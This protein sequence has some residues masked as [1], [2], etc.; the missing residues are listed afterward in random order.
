VARISRRKIGDILVEA[1]AITEDQLQEALAEQKHSNKR[2]G[3]LLVEKDFVTEE[4]IVD[5]L[6]E[7]LNI[8]Q[9]NL[10]S[11]DI[12]T[13]VATSIPSYLAQ[14]YNVIPIAQEKNKVIL[15]MADPMNIVA[16]DDVA[17]IT[18]KQVE[19]A[20]ATESSIKHAISQFFGM[21][22]SKRETSAGQ[23]VELE[24]EEELER[25]RA[26][27]EDAPI[28]RVV[29]S[30]IAQA[31]KEG[32]SDIHM[33]PFKDGFQVRMR[34]DG[35]LQKMAQP[36]QDTQALLVSRVKIMANLDIAERRLPQDGRIQIKVD[37]RLGDVNMRVSTMPTIHGEK[38]VIRIL[39]KEKIVLP[40]EKLGL[41]DHNY[42]VFKQLLMNHS[43]MILVTGPTGCGKT[44]TLYSALNYLN[45]PQDN[46]ITVEDPVEYYLN[47]INQVQ[48]NPRVD[49][50]FARAL[51]TIL[52]QDPDIIMVGEIRDLE[53]AEIATRA[54]LTG[55]LVLSS[56][57]TNTA[58][59]TVSRLIDMGVPGYL[60]VSSV[61]GVMTQRLV[62]M[63]C[64][65]CR[66]R[67]TPNQEDRVLF[68]KLFGRKAPEQLVRGRGC[69][70]CNRSGYRGRLAIHEIM[71]MNRALRELVLKGASADKLQSQAEQQGM[72]PL[73]QDGYQKLQQELTSF[74]EIVRV[75]FSSGLEEE[76]HD[77]SQ[78]LTASM[79]ADQQTNDQ[80][81][82]E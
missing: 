60:I 5:V 45:R 71:L 20:L 4:R 29:N 36:P 25:I 70:E 74:E 61:A 2:L 34:I 14:R 63:I 12:G 11:Y 35:V 82:E 24:D 6:E 68:H 62:R 50:T 26:Q 23:S 75:A 21:Q 37:P 72:I 1:G 18:Q 58:A 57:H 13:E 44:T 41:R 17:M 8:P 9:V 81:T 56:L 49:L 69:K 64:P 73:L 7:Q 46:I 27:V 15:A 53:T 79:P 48:V 43:G 31:V 39:E 42:Q 16:I 38:V 33:E 47:G 59:Q 77:D 51:R 76:D 3:E 67:Y 10:Y 65:N 19:I 66:E 32:A 78:P 52:R 55:H 28:V 54:A 22:E 30:F 40:L 80:V